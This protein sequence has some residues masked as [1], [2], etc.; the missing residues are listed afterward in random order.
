MRKLLLFASLF[1]L[2]GLSGCL[3]SLSPSSSTNT[4]NSPKPS[5][6]TTNTVNVNNSNTAADDYK[7]VE[8]K[9]FASADKL[10]AYS[11]IVPRVANSN[12]TQHHGRITKQGSKTGRTTLVQCSMSA[13]RRSEYLKKYYE[14]VKAR[15]GH[16]KAKIA[17]A[18]KYLGIIYNT[19][20]NNWVF[21]DSSLIVN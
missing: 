12:E 5:V 8:I 16:G 3:S 9:D 14:Q 11:G 1:C 10:A 2:L 20:T 17:L 21:A 15:R 4:Y 6:T 7:D 19:L 18:R 13:I